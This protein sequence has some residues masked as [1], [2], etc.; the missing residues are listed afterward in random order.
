MYLSIFQFCRNFQCG[1]SS[2]YFQ[3]MS[4]ASN[5]I[6]SSV[7]TWFWRDMNWTELAEVRVQWVRLLIFIYAL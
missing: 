1:I 6:A 2:E 4:V 7:A 3:G 5:F